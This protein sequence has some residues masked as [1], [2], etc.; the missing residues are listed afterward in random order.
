MKGDQADSFHQ[1]PRGKSSTGCLLLKRK[2]SI[3]NCCMGRPQCISN[4][5][6]LGKL[7]LLASSH[8]CTKLVGKL[9]RMYHFP[10]RDMAERSTTQY[11]ASSLQQIQHLSPAP[12]QSSA[13]D[14]TLQDAQ[15]CDDNR[16]AKQI[17]A[18]QPAQN[19]YEV[20]CCEAERSLALWAFTVISPT[21]A[22]PQETHSTEIDNHSR[23]KRSSICTIVRDPSFGA[24]M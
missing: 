11:D 14:C 19:Y 15:I 12:P 16:K 21:T 22:L 1:D 20:P 24:F 18:R 7:T 3:H 10:S 9:T 6:C 23:R 13:A 17:S 5:A 4:V 2:V 8:P